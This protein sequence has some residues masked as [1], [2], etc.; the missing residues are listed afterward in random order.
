VGPFIL[1]FYTRCSEL[2]ASCSGCLTHGKEP[3]DAGWDP[4]LVLEAL[5]KG[6]ISFLSRESNHYSSVL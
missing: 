1:N 6:Q 2:L 3:E 4:E 5:E